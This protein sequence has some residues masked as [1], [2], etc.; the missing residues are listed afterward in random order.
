MDFRSI[1]SRVDTLPPL[2]DTTKIVQ[3]LYENGAENVNIDKLVMA[4][5]SD[6]SLTVNILKMINTP[7]YGFSRD[8][9]SIRQAVTLFGTQVLY[10]IV[11]N[12]SIR[13]AVK[14]NLRPYGITT[15]EF[16]D[17][18]QLQSTL[19]DR[20][21]STIN[22]Q[23]AQ[24]LSSLALI[25]ESGKLIVSQEVVNSGKIKEFL[26]GFRDS[27]DL[28]VYENEQ[29]G[30]TSYFVSGLLFEHWRLDPM[31]VSLLKGLDYEEDSMHKILHFIDTLDVIR[32]AINV[33]EVLTQESIQEAAKIVKYLNL[34]VDS[35]IKIAQ[36]LKISYYKGSMR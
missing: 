25:M 11:V 29:F 34:D 27:E 13:F 15:E 1:V 24:Y 2:S 5:E 22:K 32:T 16:N 30:T 19:M 26:K 20:W 10:G 14:A 8:I 33:K 12:F 3:D 4:I 28:A 35:F 7:F 18:C 17:I 31:Y 21:Y 23:H 6:A 36:D 9:V